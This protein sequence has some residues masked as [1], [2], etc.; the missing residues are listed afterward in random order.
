MLELQAKWERALQ[1][2]SKIRT[3]LGMFMPL[4]QDRALPELS[5]DASKAKRQIDQL[6]T[7]CEALQTK[8]DWHINQNANKEKKR[9][10]FV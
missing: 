7:K 9:K 3:K 4:P 6:L 1:V 8:I 5:A 10:A 2:Y